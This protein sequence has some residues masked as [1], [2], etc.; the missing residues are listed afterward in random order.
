MLQIPSSAFSLV[1]LSSKIVF[2]LCGGFFIGSNL[3]SQF[4]LSTPI[5]KN[6]ATRTATRIL[7]PTT[8]S[9]ATPQVTFSC[10]AVAGYI[11]I[12]FAAVFCILHAKGFP[13]AASQPPSPPPEPGLSY[14][15]AQKR[16][17]MWLW[18][19]IALFLGFIVL[20]LVILYAFSG[21]EEGLPAFTASWI[22]GLATLE[23]SFSGGL[24]AARSSL[25]AINLYISTHGREYAK[26][27]LLALASHSTCMLLV[28][29]FHRLRPSMVR[30]L[31]DY[32][33]TLFFFFILPL[34]VILSFSCFNWIAWIPYLWY[35]HHNALATAFEINLGLLRIPSWFHFFEA[36]E[37]GSISV[38][39]GSV[40]VHVAA[41]SVWTALLA[42]RGIPS[43]AR[44]VH[45]DLANRGHFLYCLGISAR[46]VAFNVPYCAVAYPTVHFRELYPLIA[47][48]I[49]MWLKSPSSRAEARSRCGWLASRYS[50]W[51]AIQIADFRILVSTLWTLFF[52]SIKTCARTW[53]ALAWGHRL[54]IIVPVF[55]FY[56]YFCFIPVARRVRNWR[57]RRRRR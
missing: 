47:Q 57:R 24:V 33:L 19:L 48:T 3:F 31:A 25:S 12:I 16:G 55:V 45:R 5:A 50:A 43:A 15:A 32:Y 28:G 42:I 30:N 36:Y 40:I 38:I 21:G 35:C 23:R 54:L 53:G 34:A 6:S 39:V 46:I 10:I 52:A 49:W 27:V 8:C 11:T 22:R 4:I 26:I 17:S 18:W 51:K 41:S 20:G 14:S 1:S 29:S 37:P 13:R 44:A 56:S 9:H 2:G 7:L